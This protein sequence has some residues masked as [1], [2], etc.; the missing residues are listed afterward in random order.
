MKYRDL[1]R[2]LEEDGWQHVRTRGSH[3][4]YR[5]KSKVGIVVVAGHTMGLEVSK[6]L[7]NEI[8]KQAGL[9]K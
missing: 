7:L 6:G 1:V 9:K 3:R 8:L 4:I 2:L 5:H